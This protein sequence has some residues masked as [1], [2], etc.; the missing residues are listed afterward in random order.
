M[1][2]V[3]YVT[4]AEALAYIQTHYASTDELRIAWEAMTEADQV[5]YLQ[6]SFDA[7]ETLPFRGR[8]AVSGQP[9][10]FPRW[11]E[12]EVPEAVKKAQIENAFN[13]SDSA[14]DEE[15]TFYDKLWRYG[16][17]SYK[18]GNL[19]ES[20]SSGAWGR[21]GTGAS[22]VAAGVTSTVAVNLLQPYLGGGFCIE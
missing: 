12:T 5:V 18:I 11:P 9:T 4:L 19:S 7:I 16:V 14:A 22:T 1:A 15:A 21:S 6:K 10:A 13:L 2:A 20:S 8:K 17:E 3:G